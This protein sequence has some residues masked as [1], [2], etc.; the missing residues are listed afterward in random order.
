MDADRF[1]AIAKRLAAGPASRRAA[2]RALAGGALGGLLGLLDRAGVEDAGAHDA[3]RRCKKIKDRQQR[4]RC[5]KK[6]RA[7]NRRHCS[8]GPDGAV[9]HAAEARFD[10]QPL[11]V[12]QTVQQFGSRGETAGRMAL[13]LG[14]APLLTHEIE[15]AAGTVT[16]TVTYGEAFR[17]INQAWFTND[18]TTI[19]GEIDGRA[20]EPLPADGDPRQARFADGGPP[21]EVRVDPELAKAIR[22][23][24]QRAKEEAKACDPA[25]P[26][27]GHVGAANRHP[28]Q[29]W[30]CQA[31]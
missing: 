12:E 19:Q 11:R 15:G 2:L 23:L 21:P 10:G 31:L 20:I 27:G 16:V 29:D 22:A 8:V 5:I 30:D 17:G 9:N 4:K 26:A 28:T 3:L 24:L 7:H 6:A 25:P 14:G 18:G 13:T 1:D